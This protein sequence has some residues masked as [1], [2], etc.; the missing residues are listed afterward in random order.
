MQ[1]KRLPINNSFYD[2]LHHRWHDCRDHPI[3]LL[4]AEN[5]LRNPWIES[6]VKEKRG[7]NQCILDVGCGGGLLT[8]YLAK[9]GHQV[10]GVDLS[11]Q[12][13]EIARQKDETKTVEYKRASAYDLPFPNGHFDAVSAMDLL[14]HVEEPAQVIKEASRVLKPGGLFFFHTFNRNLLSYLMVIRGVE[15]CFSNAPENMHVYSLFIKPEELKQ[16]CH[17]HGLEVESFLGVS[18]NM[19]CSSFWKMVFTRKVDDRFTFNFVPSLLTGYSGYAIKN[20][21]RKDNS[22]AECRTDRAE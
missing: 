4:R 13:L 14:E 1:K 20:L 15:W 16:I 22:A 3:A 12:S 9:M 6:V 5:A 11:E 2:E 7:P 19:S 17:S 8:N 10:S 18:P 21:C